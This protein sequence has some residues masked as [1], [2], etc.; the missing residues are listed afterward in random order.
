MNAKLVLL[1]LVAVALPLYFVG[2][3]GLTINSDFWD[4]DY[5]GVISI[6]D[7]WQ[8]NYS[9]GLVDC[10]II[11]Q[12]HLNPVF[13]NGYDW[14][15]DGLVQVAEFQAWAR[16]ATGDTWN[17]SLNNPEITSVVYDLNND[18]LVSI[19]DKYRDYRLS[20]GFIKRGDI[21][22]TDLNNVLNNGYDANSD[23]YVQIAEFQAAA[24][25]LTDDTWS[26]TLQHTQVC[27]VICHI[28]D[29]TVATAVSAGDYYYNR[30]YYAMGTL[31]KT[32]RG[33]ITQAEIDDAIAKGFDTSAN[34]YISMA[35]YDNY[36]TAQD[37]HSWYVYRQ[38]PI[39]TVNSDYYSFIYDADADGTTEVELGD[40]YLHQRANGE[41][42]EEGTIGQNCS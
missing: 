14:N 21:T 18:Y 6:G 36:K 33:I 30:Y 16:W 34:G 32:E 41:I 12:N 10:G 15:S 38:S 39:A 26:I 28:Y 23:G 22:Q 24:N 40:P 35:E 11:A 9:T 7:F 13:A 3:T 8:H 4:M 25:G 2:A 1:V 27:Y 37:V 20:T 42:H 5:N 19:G 17:M 31:I 29:Q